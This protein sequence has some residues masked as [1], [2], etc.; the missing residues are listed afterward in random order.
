[1]TFDNVASDVYA[2]TV[3]DTMPVVTSVY[4]DNGAYMA[5]E[6]IDI[7]VTFDDAVT[8]DG[9]PQLTLDIGADDTVTV[10]YSTPAR[11]DTNDTSIPIYGWRNTQ[12]S[13]SQR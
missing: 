5:G 1:M 8:V 13:R 7:T 10:N 4:A 2:V 9:F 11:L 12:F 6:T 3:I